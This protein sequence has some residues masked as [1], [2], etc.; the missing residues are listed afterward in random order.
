LS[1]RIPFDEFAH[2]GDRPIIAINTWNHLFGQVNN[3]ADR[4]CVTC[5]AYPIYVGSRADVEHLFGEFYRT[6]WWRPWAVLA[7][8]LLVGILFPLPKKRS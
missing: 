1:A 7:A 3:N 4:E 8:F 5:S 2:D 6:V